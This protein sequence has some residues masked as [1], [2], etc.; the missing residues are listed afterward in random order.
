[1]TSSDFLALRA[2]DK[3][4]GPISRDEG[5]LDICA[6]GGQRLSGDNGVRVRRSILS[7]VEIAHDD[8]FAGNMV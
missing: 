4:K 8:P 1:L 5:H 7:L 2:D 6:Q 3:V